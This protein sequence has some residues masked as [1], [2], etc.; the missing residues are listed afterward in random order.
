M[1]HEFLYAIKKDSLIGE[2][3]VIIISSKE[4]FFINN[5]LS[6]EYTNEMY[7]ELSHMLTNTNLSHLE[8]YY[9][10]HDDI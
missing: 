6:N 10:Q 8:E 7:L 4:L 5:S 9:Y 2:G 3:F 1:E